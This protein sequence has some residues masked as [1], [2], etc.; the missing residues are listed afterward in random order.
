MSY[1]TSDYIAP[2]QGGYGAP[3]PAQQPIYNGY[4]WVNPTAP[5]GPSQFNPNDLTYPGQVT[6]PRSPNFVADQAKWTAGQ[7]GGIASGFTPQWQPYYN[8]AQGLSNQAVTNS[9][10]QYAGMAQQYGGQMVNNA[11]TQ[12][13]QQLAGNPAYAQW[14]NLLAQ[15]GKEASGTA[16]QYLQ[17]LWSRSANERLGSS[18]GAFASP[19]SQFAANQYGRLNADQAN[20][21]HQQAQQ[22][23][24]NTI[25]QGNQYFNPYMSGALGAGNQLYG[26]GMGYA[27]NAGNQPFSF[28]SAGYGADANQMQ[29][30]GQAFENKQMPKS[31][32]AF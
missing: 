26:Q 9:G 32:W 14:G 6:G 30:F 31:Y 22:N 3:T 27:Q 18:M 25:Q 4:G 21:F 8:Q 20:T 7:Y 16:P 13:N 11:N 28:A 1:Q 24:G 5:Q 29:Q 17:E 12:W 2:Q 10:Q 15:Q 23:L 19:N